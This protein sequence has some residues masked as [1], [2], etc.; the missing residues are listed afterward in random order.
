[1][2]LSYTTTNTPAFAD[3]QYGTAANVT[4]LK[5][6][7]NQVVDRRFHKQV[8]KKS[9]FEVRGMVGA[10]QY[11]E[12]DDTQTAPGFPVIRKDALND[13]SG[14]VVKMGLS[15]NI[16]SDHKTGG[17]VGDN[18][19][20]DNETNY[21]F[22]SLKVSIERWREA[23]RAFAGMNRQRFPFEGSIEGVQQD[24][25]Q[26]YAA[27]IKDTSLLYAL[28]AGYAPHLFRV[29][30]TS[31]NDPSP[32][33]NTLFGNDQTL[34]T[35]RTIANIVGGGGDNL[36]GL[37]FEIADAYMKQ[38]DFDPVIVDGEEWWVSLISPKGSMI[39]RRDSDFRNAQLYARERGT[40]NPLFK[41]AKYVYNNCIIFEYDKIRT[42]LG[43]NDPNGITVSSNQITE[44]SYSGIGGGVAAGDLHQ[45]IF[46][47]ANAVALADGQVQIIGRKEDDYGNIIG[48]GV[49]QIFGARRTDW[50]PESGSV[51]N[52]SSLVIVNTSVT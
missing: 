8:Q 3:S 44:A 43:G 27:N 33:P 38:N 35:T 34:S 12:G 14:D 50:A 42:I 10:D 41:Y 25:L 40:S 13:K 31:N 1:M 20:V 21:D 46:L 18:Q 39:L 36:K 49:D 4:G 30:G 17:K 37:T 48:T 9:F 45:T 52:Q 51:S 28:W 16:S 15:R 29:H 23:V 11:R 6:L 5:T 24:V 2:A 32:N 22:Y 47:G 19:L 7:V 26:R